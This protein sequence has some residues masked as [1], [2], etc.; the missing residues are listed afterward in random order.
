VVVVRRRRRQAA[1]QALADICTSS[2]WSHSWVEG[3]KEGVRRMTPLPRAGLP[4]FLEPHL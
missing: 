1:V 2:V 4:Q 3:N